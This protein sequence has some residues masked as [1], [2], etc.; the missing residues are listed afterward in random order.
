MGRPTDWYVLDLDGDPTPGDPVQVLGLAQRV[1]G[2]ADDVGAALRSIRG[3]SGDSAVQS[4]TGLTADEYRSQ[5]DDLPGEL[6]KLERSYRLCGDAL[7]AYWPKLQQAQ[8]DADRALE[9]GRQARADLNSAQSQLNSATDWVDRANAQSQQYQQ[10]GS[11]PDVPPPT[12]DQVRAATRNANEAQA[13]QR[14]AQSALG[15]AQAMLNAAKQLAEEARGLRDNAAHTAKRAIDDASDAGIQNKAWYEKAVDFVADHW[16]EIVAV[17][18]VVVAVLGVIVMIIGGP[19]AWLVLAAALVVLADTLMKYADGKASLW[20]V[21]FA[22]LDCIPGFKGLTTAGGLLKLA[23][24]GLKGMKGGLGEMANGLRLAR[25][26]D[27]VPVGAAAPEWPIHGEVP[28]TV[29]RQSQPLSCVSAA[30]E[31]LS[32]GRLTEAD[33]MARIGVPSD[34]E[35]LARE[36]RETTGQSWIGGMI[37]VGGEPADT[38]RV[39]NDM[40]QPWGAEVLISTD[41]GHIVNQ[42][43]MHHM[44]V[45]DGL[46]DLGRVK[47]HDPWEGSS[48]SVELD[49]FLN[50]WTEKAVVQHG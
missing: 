48:Y 22:A 24:G 23:K 42:G 4:W 21:L 38:F 35:T 28:G 40:G 10:N 1:H 41:V 32:R 33:L 39:L 13:S 2:F 27:D 18:K 6:D 12:P 37:S 15:S 26:A 34:A 29:V 20:D 17:C 19:L 47:I 31:V 8:G 50:H 46:D 49:D 11:R 5:F 7:A 3:L 30:G 44:V 43:N 16:D 45:V 14:S 25:T 36:L 9:Q